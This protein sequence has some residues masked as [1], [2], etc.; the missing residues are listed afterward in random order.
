MTEGFNTTW[1]QRFPTKTFVPKKKRF[2][3]ACLRFDPRLMLCR[4]HCS[5][6][7]FWSIC[8]DVTDR[9]LP[10]WG[11]TWREIEPIALLGV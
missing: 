1:P 5:S 9:F 10:F 8:R 4:S 3:V 6:P 2:V 11:A 7:V